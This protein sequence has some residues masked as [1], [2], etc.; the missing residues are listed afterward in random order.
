MTLLKHFTLSLLFFAGPLCGASLDPAIGRLPSGAAYLKGELYICLKTQA[1]ITLVKASTGQAHVNIAN[2]ATLHPSIL[3]V[4][5]GNVFATKW[6]NREATPTALKFTATEIPA[7]ARILKAELRGGED[8]AVVAEAL[9]AHPDIEWVEFN[10]LHELN[11]VPNDF[12]WNLQWGPARIN[13]TNAWDVP[14]AITSA[15]VAI[16]DTGVDF[17]HAD[18]ASRIVYQKGFGINL[19]GDAQRD[20]RGGASIDHG[21]HVA[22][23]AAAIRDNNYGIAGIANADI[24]AMGCAVWNPANNA[25]FVGYADEA[26]LDAINN[27]ATV[28]NCSFGC[29]APIPASTKIA[30]DVAELYGVVV[31]CAAGNDGTNVSLSASA[32]WAQHSWPLFVSNTQTNDLLNPSS[33]FGNEIHLAAPG[34]HIFS[35]VTTNNDPI[36]PPPGTGEYEYLTGTSM[37]APHVAG[38]VAMVRSMNATRI[39]GAGCK[40]FLYRTALDIGTPGKDTSFGYGL[41]Q[42]DPVSLKILKAANTFTGYIAAPE[43]AQGTFDLP[44]AD[45]PSAI[46]AT[47]AGGKLV[48]N[49]GLTLSST[50]TYPAQ[51]ISAPVTLTAF[52]DHPVTIGH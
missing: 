47:P 39:A 12:E 42:L 9:R 44:Y 5:G 3:S 14:Q 32:G 19:S 30:L 37:S 16:I 10:W 48:L 38:A 27:G 35:T 45:I 49:G 50:F 20:R 36:M 46:A 25:Y 7:V 11:S 21:T 33:N 15:R 28:I 41:L 26:I 34:T 40:Y 1:A 52:P 23:I 8:A 4:M 18:L 24:M 17:T 29:A 6:L 2:M 43:L 13:A 51:T 22:G 31:V